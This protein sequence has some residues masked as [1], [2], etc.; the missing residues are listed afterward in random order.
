MDTS[1]GEIYPFKEINGKKLKTSIKSEE[2]EFKALL[3]LNKRTFIRK[4]RNIMLLS[5]LDL[6]P[7]TLRILGSAELIKT[8]TTTPLFYKYKIKKGKVEKPHHP[9]G[10]ICKGLAQSIEGA[11]K[12]VGRELESPFTKVINI[13]GTKGAVIVGLEDRDVN[14][15]KDDEIIL[16]ELRS[17]SI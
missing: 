16:K 6:P 7:T 17:F 1:I 4:K 8:Y 13:F 12:M 2:I 10:I 15:Q 11:R 5:R 9:Q 3:I 14:I